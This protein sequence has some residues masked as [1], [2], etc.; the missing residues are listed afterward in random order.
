MNFGWM[1]AMYLVGLSMN[2]EREHSYVIAIVP[3]MK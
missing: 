1:C 2:G 3:N